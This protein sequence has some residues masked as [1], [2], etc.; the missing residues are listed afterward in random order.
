MTENE[1]DNL[2]S[3]QVSRN[4]TFKQLVIFLVLLLIFLGIQRYINIY[5]GKQVVEDNGLSQYSFSE[6]L[7]VAK[8]EAKPIL[9]NF[10]ALWCAACR[11]MEKSV[12]SDPEFKAVLKKNAV[13]VR[14]EETEQKN[15]ELFR[16]YQV[17][18]FPTLVLLDSN[19][20][21]IQRLGY[22]SDP[23]IL[24]KLLKQ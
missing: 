2:Q 9:A 13:Y 3:K 22:I 6:A 14:V 5:L 19:G 7:E 1:K 4:S 16:R 24:I 8:E 21:V 23:D 12:L 10:S 11:K 15:A 20:E 17:T 18:G